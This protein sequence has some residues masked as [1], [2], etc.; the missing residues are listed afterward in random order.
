MNGLIIQRTSRADLTTNRRDRIIEGLAIP[1]ARPTEVSDDGLT[2]YLEE[3]QL[4]VFADML[5]PA[6]RGRVRLN[7]THDESTPF[8]WV[9]RTLQLAESSEGLVGQWRVD[10]SPFG[11]VALA[12]ADDGQLPGLSVSAAVR[13]SV[14]RGDVKVRT[15]ALLRHVA[16]VEQPAF[17]EALVTAVREQRPTEPPTVE[18]PAGTAHLD[19]VRRWLL[20]QRRR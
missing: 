15:S 20:A 1:Y 19:D 8:T 10:E 12:K 11:D 18:A 7:F 13:A 17:A 16:L 9:G 5:Q 3:W 2:S 4:G 14:M 6:N